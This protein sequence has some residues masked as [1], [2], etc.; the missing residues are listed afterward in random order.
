MTP[1]DALATLKKLAEASRQ[2]LHT[3]YMYVLRRAI[4]LQLGADAAC[5]SAQ[6][7]LKLG[8]NPEVTVLGA[9]R[10]AELTEEAVL[11]DVP[12]LLGLGDSCAENQAGTGSYYTPAG[13]AR[14]MAENALKQ[15]L[16]N[17]FPSQ[18]SLVNRFFAGVFLLPEEARGLQAS[19]CQLRILDLACGN[20]VFLNACLDCY[21]ALA[22]FSGED[23]NGRNFISQALC[24][25]DIRSD[26]LESWVISLGLRDAGL[27]REPWPL[28]LACLSSVE[29]DAVMDVPWLEPVMRA[30][31]FDLVIGNPP[32]L[33]EK[34]N[35]EQFEELKATPFGA[36]YYEGRMDLF[37]YFLHRGIELLRDGGILCQ[38][39]TSYYATADFAT[40]L[41]KHLQTAGGISGLVVFNEHKV[42]DNAKG[43]HLILFFEKGEPQGGAV[44]LIFN[45]IKRPKGY[46]YSEMSF[47]AEN[48]GYRRYVIPHRERLFDA[49][50]HIVLDPGRWE[51]VDLERLQQV[52]PDTLKSV[53]RIN[54]GIVSGAD[55]GPDSG[56]FVL[57]PHEVFPEA[58]P[59]LVPWYKNGDIRRYKAAASTDK[60]LLYLC[61]E[62]EAELPPAVLEHLKPHR[63]RLM[64]RREC[65]TGA[66]PW[67]GL[68]WPRARDLFEGPKLVA[69]QRSSE[70]R[71]AY[72]EGPWFAS[73]DVY[74][75][76]QP[77]DGISFFALLAYLNSDLIF[78]WLSHFGKRK[79]K[80]LELYATPLGAVP[81]NRQ[82]LVA[83][84]ALEAL[85]LALYTAAGD[86]AGR[87]K[88]LREQVDG[89]LTAQLHHKPS[90][91]VL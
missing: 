65:Q 24:G 44:S 87:V 37:Y 29:G 74:F 43:H 17:R 54:Q 72:S 56:I 8:F 35:R 5:Y 22:G 48:D 13:V 23:I 86:D 66:R 10:S 2:P 27:L 61:N 21:L 20:G 88:G 38:L 77:A 14:F 52:C 18:T 16:M 67:T 55:R 89:W 1:V 90:E 36:R 7:A 83:G 26:A 4:G 68:Q 79:G 82:W 49:R 62:T 60:R 3:V 59:W 30:G 25:M 53:I 39:T 80:Q 78:N 51:H 11:S 75:L 45:E 76:T 15:V 34:G 42:F 41:R 85:G 64:S 12:L 47:E 58:E 63:Q 31:G 71:F 19:F 33:G 91:T 84:G 6:M 50:G 57:E 73:A 46:D 81:V 69:P 28:K 70:N 32:Y 40:R 9:D